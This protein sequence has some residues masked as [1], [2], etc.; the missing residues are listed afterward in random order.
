MST[1][2]QNEGS[3][4]SAKTPHMPS[5]TA[6][7]TGQRFRCQV[8]QMEVQV[9]ADCNSKDPAHVHFQCCEQE[10]QRV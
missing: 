4:L 2:T 6:P 8:C 5:K 10:M 3:T 9:T 1:K 7:K